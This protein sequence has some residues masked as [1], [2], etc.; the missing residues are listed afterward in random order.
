MNYRTYWADLRARLLSG[1]ISYDVALVESTPILETM[2]TEGKAIA[3]KHKR[4]FTPF[5]FSK[6]IR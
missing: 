5:C 4:H 2:N 1:A 3:K 6:M